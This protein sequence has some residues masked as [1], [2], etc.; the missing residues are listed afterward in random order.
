M[1]GRLSETADGAVW[2]LSHNLRQHAL[3]RAAKV[4]L[5]PD[6]LLAVLRRARL[7]AE[8]GLF[9]V[10]AIGLGRP[11]DGIASPEL[12]RIRKAEILDRRRLRRLIFSSNSEVPACEVAPCAACSSVWT[13]MPWLTAL[14]SFAMK[15]SCADWNAGD[16]RMVRSHIPSGRARCEMLRILPA[17]AGSH[18]IENKPSRLSAHPAPRASSARS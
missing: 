6:Q 17:E 5:V 14:Y 2:R 7:H 8:Q 3:Q 13:L 4:V 11:Q 15:A 9:R 18:G 12:D 16:I 10:Q 1:S